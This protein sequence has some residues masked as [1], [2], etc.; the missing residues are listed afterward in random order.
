MK[1]FYTD[2]S[3]F[4][5]KVRVVV[6]HHGIE[7][8]LEEVNLRPQP[9]EL[10]ALNPVGKIPALA[11]DNGRLIADSPVICEY[12]DVIGKGAKLLPEE[13]GARAAIKTL[14]AV[15]DGI[16]DAAVAIVYEHLLRMEAQRSMD[17]LAKHTK[18]IARSVDWLAAHL[19]EFEQGT[20]LATIAIATTLDYLRHRMPDH[21]IEQT[22][23]KTQ[24][25]LVH[26]LEETLKN[27]I[28]HGNAPKEW[29]M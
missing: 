17:I 16:L 14:E 15:T 9:P 13:A 25:A 24:P 27:P 22:W 8:T 26:W 7:L 10:L 11:L 19:G 20:T 28:F 6:A 3:P 4:A 1:L 21:S 18:A 5:R 12:L 2:R 29:S 23:E